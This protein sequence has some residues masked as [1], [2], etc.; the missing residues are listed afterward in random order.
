[1]RIAGWLVS[2]V[3]CIFMAGSDTTELTKAAILI[4]TVV[5]LFQ[6]V[7]IPVQL[8]FGGENGRMALMGIIIVVFSVGFAVEKFSKNVFPSQEVIQLWL[9]TL[10][11][12]S[13]LTMVLVLAIGLAIGIA[14]SVRISIRVMENREY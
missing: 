10:E 8:K 6:L 14:V 13:F 3:A 12:I 5:S 2:T 4:Y 7:M 9:Q 11:S 1:M